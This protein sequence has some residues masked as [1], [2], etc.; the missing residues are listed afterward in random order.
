M[1]DLKSIQLE[2]HQKPLEQDQ[3]NPTPWGQLS[4][5]F[6]DLEKED[7]S[8]P[9]AAVLSTTNNE[10]FPS[11]RVILVKEFDES[12]LVFFTDYE[13]RKGQEILLNPQV[14]LLFF[15]KELDR[16]VRIQGKIEKI[17]RKKSEAYFNSRPFGSQVSAYSSYQ[18]KQ[19][20][21]EELESKVQ[22]NSQAFKD[23]V[24]CPERWG[25]YLIS[26]ENAEFWQGRPSR[27]HD[28]FFYERE[29]EIWK[30]S[31]LSP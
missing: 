17:S 28:R 15:W 13:S 10:N 14:S 29:G 23:Q 3:L 2:Y 24:P 9:N 16:Q 21:K 6:D 12:G 1:R 20:S 25:G 8:Y 30:I 5:W 31:R 18:S 22:E 4:Q 11:S 27:L 7:V 26:F 19:V